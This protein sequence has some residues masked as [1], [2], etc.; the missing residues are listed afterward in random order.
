METIGPCGGI[1]R[2]GGLKIRCPK[3]HTGWI[4]VLGTMK[5]KRYIRYGGSGPCGPIYDFE[6]EQEMKMSDDKMDIH[7]FF[8]NVPNAVEEFKKK[9][10]YEEHSLEEWW[11][12]LKEYIKDKVP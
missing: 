2:H 10:A 3:G 6:Y 7:E 1:A 11:D 5:S 12:L 9:H 8:P 4:P